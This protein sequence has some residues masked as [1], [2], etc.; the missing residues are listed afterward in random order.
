MYHLYQ[1]SSSSVSSKCAV[2]F[3]TRYSFFSKLTYILVVGAL[4]TYWAG[5]EH[6]IEE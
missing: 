3:I 4:N 6:F 1:P 5:Q 2:E